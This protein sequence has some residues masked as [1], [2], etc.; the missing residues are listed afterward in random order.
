MA[1]KKDTL[2]DLL[3]GRDL[4]DRSSYIAIKLNSGVITKLDASSNPVANLDILHPAL[5]T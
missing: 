2:D 5:G 4:P 1:I 3:A